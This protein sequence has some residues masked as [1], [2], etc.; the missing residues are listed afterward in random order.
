MH[1][2]QK[3]SGYMV[4]SMRP[5]AFCYPLNLDAGELRSF[6]HG[7]P[8]CF[9]PSGRNFHG[10]RAC[11]QP[12]G[13]NFH[14][15]RTCCY[16]SGRNFHGALTCFYPSGRNFHGVRTCCYPSGRNFHGVRTCCQPSG[17][18]FHGVSNAQSI[19]RACSALCSISLRRGARKGSVAISPRT[20][21]K[22]A[23]RSLSGQSAP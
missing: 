2:S 4:S 23:C 15:V 10:V 7:I 21:W 16:P 5:E 18:N 3:A 9:Y 13:R 19:A 11:C 12:S 8:T 6:F 14:G 20:C 22:S 17:R 1:K